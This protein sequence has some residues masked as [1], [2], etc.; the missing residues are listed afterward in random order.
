MKLK[1]VEGD[2]AFFARSRRWLRGKTG[3]KEKSELAGSIP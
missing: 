2:D 3:K 1:A